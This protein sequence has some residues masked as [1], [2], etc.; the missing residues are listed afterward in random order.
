VKGLYRDMFGKQV[1]MSSEE[2]KFHTKQQSLNS[3]VSPTDFGIP[4]A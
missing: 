4:K 3:W 2:V 1:G